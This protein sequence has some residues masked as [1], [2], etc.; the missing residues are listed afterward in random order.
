V[1]VSFI[2]WYLLRRA[3]VFP[4]SA[5]SLPLRAADDRASAERVSCRDFRGC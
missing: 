1:A 5:V 3:W 4:G 2:G